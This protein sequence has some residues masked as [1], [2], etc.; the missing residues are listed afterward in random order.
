MRTLVHVRRGVTLV[1][2]LVVIAILALLMG[3]LLAAVQQ[4]RESAALLQNKNNLRQ[5]V[6]AVHQVAGEN[7]GKI[8]DLMRSSMQGANGVSCDAAL[9]YRLVPYVQGQPLNYHPNLS[10]GEILDLA[11]PNNVKVYHNLADPSWDYDPAY[12]NARCKCSYALN[13]FAFDGSVSLVA[14][15]PDGA[16]QTIA[17]ADKYFARC[18]PNVTLSKPTSNDFTQIFDPYNGEIYGRRR[19]TFADRGW[20]DVL[21]VTDPATNTTRPSVAGKT[22][23]V[24]PRPEEVDPSIPQTPHRAG[25]TVAMFDGSVRTI[26]PSV[27]ESVF[28]A[29]VTP[30]GGEVVNPD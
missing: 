30:A 24:R 19:A 4:V 13:M 1:E 14:S 7:E 12:A 21:P 3:L 2:V 16:S 8:Q 27:A 18:S 29:Q 25:L 6:L 10:L 20:H 28:W 26:S 5:I 11:Q 22:F 15:L 9:F 23:Q 17:L